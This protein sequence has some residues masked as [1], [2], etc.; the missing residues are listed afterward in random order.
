MREKGGQLQEQRACDVVS[1][2][3]GG[4]GSSRDNAP[5]VSRGEAEHM[6]SDAGRLQDLALGKGGESQEAFGK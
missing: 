5:I 4:L 3:A 6:G 1:L 2:G